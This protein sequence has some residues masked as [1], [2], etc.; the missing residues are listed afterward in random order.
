MGQE[1][2]FSLFTFKLYL[3]VG[4]KLGTKDIQ[5]PFF[6]VSLLSLSNLRHP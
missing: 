4:L 2:L 3:V 1:I 6:T 5:V